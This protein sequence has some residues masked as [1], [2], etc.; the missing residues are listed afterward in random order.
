M[1]GLFIC[2]NLV[3]EIVLA[4]KNLAVQL[5]YN[6]DMKSFYITVKQSLLE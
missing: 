6:K 5:L 4:K 2:D 3:V 1:R